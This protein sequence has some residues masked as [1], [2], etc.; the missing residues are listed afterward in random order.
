M[1][2]LLLGTFTLFNTY[3]LNYLTELKGIPFTE[4]DVR[5]LG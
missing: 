2:V 3:K 1:F 4:V 5:N